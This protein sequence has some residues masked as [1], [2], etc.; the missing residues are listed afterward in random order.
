[1]KKQMKKQIGIIEKD[2]RVCLTR[3]QQDK[4]LLALLRAIT[5]QSDNHIHYYWQYNYFLAKLEIVFQEIIRNANE[6]P[7]HREGKVNEVL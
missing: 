3:Y 2:L 4:D 5:T 6:N 7:S 1:M